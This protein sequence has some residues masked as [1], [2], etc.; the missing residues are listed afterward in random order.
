MVGTSEDGE[1]I[2]CALKCDKKTVIKGFYDFNIHKFIILNF[3][4]NKLPEGIT[5][6]KILQDF[7]SILEI[8]YDWELNKNLIKILE[9][10]ENNKLKYKRKNEIKNI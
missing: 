10:I 9:L 3:Y 6:L 8:D 4:K 5:P 1:K 7:K 2:Y